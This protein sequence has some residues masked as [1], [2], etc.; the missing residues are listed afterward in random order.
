[1]AQKKLNVVITADTTQFERQ[2][3]IASNKL[4]DV[5]KDLENFGKSISKMTGLLAA[6]GA[7]AVNAAMKVQDAF[8]TIQTGTGATGEKLRGLQDEF[9]KLARTVPESYQEVATAIADLNTMLG[10]SD[11]PLR[12]MGKAMLDVTRLAGG[13]LKGNIASVAKAMNAWQVDA[14][15]GTAAVNDLYVVSQNTGAGIA[16]L[17]ALMAKNS[18]VLSLLGYNYQTAAVLLGQFEHEGVDTKKAMS[19]LR[20]AAA[21]LVAFGV[22]DIAGG[23]Q[24]IVDAVKNAGT[25]TQATSIAMKYFGKE[26]GPVLAAAIRSGVLST[27]ELTAKLAE[28]SD[29]LAKDAKNSQ[30][31]KQKLSTMFNDIGLAMQPVGEALISLAEEYVMPLAKAFLSLSPAL[32]K[33]TVAA[34]TLVVAVGP[35]SWIFGNISTNVST[36]FKYGSK[37]Y[38]VLS[39]WATAFTEVAASATAAK[40]AMLGLNGTLAVSSGGVL[41]A[42]A[43]VAALAAAL[44]SASTYFSELAGAADSSVPHLDNLKDRIDEVREAVL[45]LSQTSWD[46][47]IQDAQVQIQTLSSELA[48]LQEQQQKALDSYALRGRSADRT[49]TP[50]DD[51]IKQKLAGIETAKNNKMILE[52]AGQYKTIY[53]QMQEELSRF[54]SA[55]SSKGAD[56]V[57]LKDSSYKKMSSLLAQLKGTAFEG[58]VQ[59]K[60]FL[61]Q[62]TNFKAPASPVIGKGGT[63]VI[64]DTAERLRWQNASGFLND[65][66]YLK[67]LRSR[68]AV[69]TG[70]KGASS[71]NKDAR[72]T[73]DELQRLMK[74]TSTKS[75]EALRWQNSAGFL[76]N[77]D[78]ADKLQSR[79]TGLTGGMS[80]VTKWGDEARS[81][82]DELQ[83]VIGEQVAPAMDTLKD[84]FTSGQITSGEYQAQLQALMEQY[85]Q[86]PG[87]TNK[88]REAMDGAKNKTLSFAESMK[89]AIDDAKDAVDDLSVTMSTGLADSFARAVAYGENLG[90]SL[91]KLG[92]DIIYTV[93]KMWM[94]QSV[95]RMFSGLFGGGSAAASAPPVPPVADGVFAKGGAFAGGIKA[96]AGG[97]LVS[98]PTLFKFAG[99]TGLMGEAGPEAIMPLRRDS[100]G[101]LGVAVS[102]SAGGVYAP[103]F[104]ITVNNE[105]SGN[106]SDEQAKVFGENFRDAVDARVIENMGKFQR[107]GYFRNSYA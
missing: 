45:S 99:G 54:K 51:K 49:S 25:E 34:A 10:L 104:N 103:Q 55:V 90:D 8:K 53:S 78:Y 30:T 105:G 7:A 38:G 87:V 72:A 19:G 48:G 16:D 1:M 31:F 70:G 37:L 13:D 95:T 14:A 77:S 64:D 5:G 27:E 32:T 85:A 73:Y 29:Q 56:F 68:L 94:L 35:I 59:L 83:R 82:F 84:R 89:A 20:T 57:S 101:R 42:L 33:G 43:A 81:T 71:W 28:L 75:D 88:I 23:F 26:G 93:M 79:L 74:N 62:L 15:A 100:S 18:D 36:L 9:K 107:M 65:D 3:R 102:G 21:Q 96:F 63:K 98:H 106:M 2:M 61:T 17:S 80:D 52:Q 46:L 58:D 91:K 97:G 66:D 39:G 41:A 76:S 24:G 22:K 69:Q 60:G 11:R 67:I 86:F 4:K 92:Q 47:K 12:E 44:Y 6:K 40:G 50:Y